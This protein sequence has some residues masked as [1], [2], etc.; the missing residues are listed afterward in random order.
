MQAEYWR[1]RRVFVTGH[2]GFKGAWLCALLSHLGARVYGY[3]LETPDTYLFH[4]AGLTDMVVRDERGDIRDMQRLTAAMRAS[5]AEVVL[6][7]AAQTVVRES[8]ANPREAFSTN[9]EGTL[10]VLEAAR[11]CDHVSRCVVVTTDKVYRN[12]EWCW[13][14]RELDPL[15]GDDPYSASKAA[16]ELVTHSM[17]VSFPREG[18]AVATARAGNVIG[19]GDATPEALIPEL[20]SAFASGRPAELRYPHA[21]RPWQH[22]LEPLNGY[23]TLAENLDPSRHDSAWNFGPA[24]ADAFSVGE[25]AD[26]LAEL[27]GGGR[28]VTSGDTGPHEAGLLMLDSAKARA[29]FGWR[30]ALNVCEALAFVAD[31][32]KSV[33]S[34][35]ES[36]REATQ[37]QVD[38]Y[39]Q[40]ANTPRSSGC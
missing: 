37:R 6:H 5:Q 26:R 2:T 31:W 30:P 19:G 28:W 13:G 22:V 39:L 17:A 16:T 40:R 12:N 10:S 3:A 23:L 9:V 15:G 18:Y 29:E 8:Y 25:V 21:V 24:A 38:E 20:L 27:W 35:R 33:T 14:Y 34:Q 11:S 7:L 4:R 32:E 36:P 1:D